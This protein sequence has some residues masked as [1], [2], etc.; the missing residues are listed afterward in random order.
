MV[1]LSPMRPTTGGNE[2]R[3]SILEEHLISSST[4]DEERVDRVTKKPKSARL[5]KRVKSK[6]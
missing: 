1:I 5:E 6:Q 4:E 3:K 2:P